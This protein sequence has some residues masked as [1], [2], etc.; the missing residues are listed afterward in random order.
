[1]ITY[2]AHGLGDASEA[3]SQRRVA[4]GLEDG[5]SVTFCPWNWY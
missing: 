3:H 5:I 2:D 4:V 1:M